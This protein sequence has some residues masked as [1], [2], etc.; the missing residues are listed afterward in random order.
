MESPALGAGGLRGT[1]CPVTTGPESRSAATGRA[2]F[3]PRLQELVSLVHRTMIRPRCNR[4][5]L[6]LARH[7]PEFAREDPAVWI[8]AA[9]NAFHAGQWRQAIDAYD[10]AIELGLTRLPPEEIWQARPRGSQH[11]RSK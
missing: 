2:K 6:L 11:C 10:Q 1:R 9:Q 3:K 5:R 4:V 8:Q 7:I